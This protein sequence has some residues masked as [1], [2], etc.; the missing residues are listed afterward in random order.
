MKL[1]LKYT[2]V[3]L[4]TAAALVSCTKKFDTIN[5]NP[6]KSTTSTAPWLATNMLTAIT[7][8]DIA[9][10]KSFCQPFILSK[11]VLWTE[12]QEDFQYN[13]IA[14]TNFGRLGVLRNIAPMLNYAANE[15]ADLKNSYT[16]LAH[17]IRAWQFFQLTMQVGDIP[18][19]DALKGESEGVIK[20]KYDDQKAVFIG[21]LNELDSANT[22]FASGADFLGDFIYG[23]SADK[24]R[25]LTNSFE[26]HVLMQLYKKTGDADLNVVNRFRDI[27]ASRPLMRDYNDNFAVT[28]VNSAGYA[29]PWSNTPIQLNSFAG[30][31]MIGA[32]LI[33]PLKNLH[34]RRLF[35]YAEPAPAQIT[36]GK[37][38]SDWDAYMSIEASDVFANTTSA[39]N[40]GNFCDFNTRYK[41]LY[42]AEPVGLL[43]HWDVQFVLAEAT[44]RGWISGTPA[45]TYYKAGIQ[46]SM[47]FLVKYTPA[48]YN[49]GMAMDS[50]YI[51]DYPA[52]APVMLAGSPDEQIQ[53]IITQKYLAGFLQGVDYNAWYENRRTGYPV[54]VLNT[55]TNRNLPATKFPVR[56]LYPQLE[57]DVN[58]DNVDAAV[59]SQYGGSDDTNQ[60]MWLLK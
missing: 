5:T 42:N 10:T 18:Y 25:R 7:S 47:N 3:P 60:V 14:R 41:E 8:T 49:H 54:F 46:S 28:Y 33:T 24:W 56:W 13:K 20:P 53:K 50:A 36:A 43:N 22:L 17:F 38:A 11:Y 52:S 2:I 44:V 27:V 12:R 55:A 16:A 21:I 34:D 6:D 1:I 32:N 39:R 15:S 35:Y 57:L 59:Q 29:Y 9:S 45:Q 51:A 30:Q 37:S 26:L 23:G 48:S 4:I 31:S 40:S 19:S 58:S